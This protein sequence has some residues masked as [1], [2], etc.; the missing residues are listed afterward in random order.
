MNSAVTEQVDF[1][2]LEGHKRDVS[3]NAEH[4]TTLLG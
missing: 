3:V 2:L 1:C 4:H